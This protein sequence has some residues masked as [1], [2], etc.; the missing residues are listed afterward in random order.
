[1]QTCALIRMDKLPFPGWLLAACRRSQ[2]LLE[3]LLMSV[4]EPVNCCNGSR[5]PCKRGEAQQ[6]AAFAEPG[7]FPGIIAPEA[8]TQNLDRPPLIYFQCQD[9]IPSPR[10][11]M[12]AACLPCAKW[13]ALHVE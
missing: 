10:Q 13:E 1:M 11:S 9:G 8:I 7:M 12:R 4:R 3:R 6:K 5:L 2:D